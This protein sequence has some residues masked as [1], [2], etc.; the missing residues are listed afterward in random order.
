MT[1]RLHHAALIVDDLEASLR[2]WRD[3]IGLDVLMDQSFEGD[4]TSLFHARADRLHSVFLGDAAIPTA[5]IVE[6]VVFEDGS[7]DGPPAPTAPA[8][9]FFLLSFYVHL[10]PTTERLANLGYPL[11]TSIEVSAGASTPGVDVADGEVATL[12]MATVV[13]PDGVLVELIGIS[14]PGE[15]GGQR[16]TTR[17]VRL[18]ARSCARIPPSHVRP[19][20]GRRPG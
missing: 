13:S 19:Y 20:A 6:L 12:Q 7:D 16:V 3:G 1:N 8:K 2:F 10:A 11:R 14:T 15:S 9:G 4:W 17:T 18:P 5:G